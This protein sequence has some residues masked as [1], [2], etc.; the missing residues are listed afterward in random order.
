MDFAVFDHFDEDL[1]GEWNALLKESV[2]NVPFLQ[3]DYL[4]TWWHHLGGGEWQQPVRL[5]IVTARENGKLTGIAPLFAARHEGVNSLLILG[6][7]EISDFLDLIVR[8]NDE[9]AF[10]SGL[11]S[12]ARTVLAEEYGVERLDLYNVLE[13]STTVGAIHQAAAELGLPVEQNRLQHSP[14]ILLP[15]DWEAYLAGIDKKQ[16]HE[17]RRKMRRAGESEFTVGWHLVEDAGQLET[18]GDELLRLMAQEKDK[19]K[20]L[21]PEMQMQMKALMKSAMDTGTLQLAFL[22]VN[23]SNAAAYMNFDYD[24]RIWVYNSGFDYTFMDYSPGWVL[25]GHLL[26]WANENGRKVFDFLRGNEDYKYRF[27]AID[28]F[29]VRLTVNLA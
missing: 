29:I 27:G 20:F 25:L 15:G 6:S 1:R 4:K 22:T 7:I 3:F 13:E 2:S 11:L 9:Q 19:E 14:Y 10:I 12:F 26:K 5:A 17:I 21:T 23:G 28:R 18:A 24:N 16:R 8:E